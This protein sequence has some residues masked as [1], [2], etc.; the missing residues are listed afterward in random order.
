V[1]SSFRATALVTVKKIWPFWQP[2]LATELVCV[3]RQLV[4]NKIEV[5]TPMAGS[6]VNLRMCKKR[7]SL[8]KTGS[9][10]SALKDSR[11][12]LEAV[13]EVI[14]TNVEGA[15]HYS[16]MPCLPMVRADGLRWFCRLIRMQMG[17]PLPAISRSST[18]GVC[19]ASR[20]GI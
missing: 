8:L 19:H 3:N 10:R 6:I 11:N 7:D 15:L 12:R 20:R 17:K 16:G 1:G 2:P 4:F 9:S 14:K 5:S 13:M 18:G